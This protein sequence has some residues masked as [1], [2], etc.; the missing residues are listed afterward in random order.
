[1]RKTHEP[2]LCYA[3]S[4]RKAPS[5]ATAILFKC[6]QTFSLEFLH[7]Q[8]AF[9]LHIHGAPAFQERHLKRTEWT[10]EF[11]ATCRIFHCMFPRNQVKT[12]DFTNQQS[13]KLPMSPP[14]PTP[15]YVLSVRP[16]DAMHLTSKVHFFRYGSKC[17]RP[18]MFESKEHD[19]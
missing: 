10:G 2:Q 16:L 14:L 1:M 17:A 7:P 18:Q 4:E 15:Q 5:Q 8:D 9:S 3:K 13:Y 11:L 19:Y 12:G 6:A